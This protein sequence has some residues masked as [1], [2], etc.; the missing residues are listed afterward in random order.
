MKNNKKIALITG[1]AGL[2]GRVFVSALLENDFIVLAID[3][4]K[5][6]IHHFDE[7][8]RNNKNF[9]FFT[10]D[11][12]NEKKINKLY[13]YIKNNFKKID[14]LI[15]SAA[16]DAKVTPSTNGNKFENLSVKEWDRLMSI[17]LKSLFLMCK[18]FGP[19]MKRN[20]GGKIINIGSDL[21][22]IAPSQYIYKNKK[23]I[24]FKPITYSVSKHAI[25]GLTKYLAEYWAKNNITVNCLSP[26]SVNHNQPPLLK[27]RIISLT[28]AGRLLDKNELKN[29]I[30]FLCSSKSN[31]ITGQNILID[32]G[33]T[34]I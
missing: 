27:K 1:A 13:L 14:I 34:I 8:I 26:G 33:R 18:K 2:L 19:F 15:N 3:I 23:N 6:T 31:Y 32:G 7:T 5:K 4:K 29:V 10:C 11:V 25:I 16:I 22:V 30:K 20:G 17:N 12:I 24:Y 21:S 28:P 9:N